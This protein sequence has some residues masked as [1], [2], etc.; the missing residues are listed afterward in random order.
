MSVFAVS[1][2]NQIGVL[3]PIAR[4]TH[5]PARASHI[6]NEPPA[7]LARAPHQ[8]IEGTIPA[9]VTNASS[10]PTPTPKIPVLSL[11]AFPA[12]SILH[13]NAMEIHQVCSI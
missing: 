9:A 11:A 3:N 1:N 4:T 5:H 2:I 13:S 7:T 12:A 6:A 8:A 10:T